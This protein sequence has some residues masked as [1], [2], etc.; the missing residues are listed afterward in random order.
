METFSN[1]DA[2]AAPAGAELLCDDSTG[3]RSIPR[4]HAG[5]SFTRGYSPSPLPGPKSVRTAL[6]ICRVRI[7]LENLLAYDEKSRV[8]GP[9]NHG[10]NGQMPINSQARCGPYKKDWPIL[11][12]FVDPARK[13]CRSCKKVSSI[14]QE[15]FVDRPRKIRGSSK[16]ASPV[17][18]PVNPALP[19]RTGK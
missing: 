15:S 19:C 2:S 7:E 11:Q 6:S 13:L 17:D 8:F 12:S 9:E 18:S 5:W 4:S 1:Q 3:S 16:K 10:G 14:E